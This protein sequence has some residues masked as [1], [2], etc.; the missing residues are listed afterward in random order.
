MDFPIW[1]TQPYL[2]SF[3]QDTSFDIQPIILGFSA[4]IGTQVTLINGELPAGLKWLNPPGATYVLINGVASPSP[5]TI[6]G[7]FTFRISQTNGSIADRTFSIDL[8]P[9]PVAP[10]WSQQQ[11]FLGY[12]DNLSSSTYVLK[13]LPPPGEHVSY[14]LLSTPPGQMTI[15]QSTGLLTYNANVITTDFTA[16]FN[17]R[18]S[19]YTA[20]SDIDL[21]IGVVAAPFSPQWITS[22]GALNNPDTGNNEFV[23]GDFVEIKLE[24]VDVLDGNVSYQLVSAPGGFP[25]VLG[26][27]GLLF[28][29]APDVINITTYVFEVVASSPNGSSSRSFTIQVVPSSQAGLLA[30]ITEPDLGSIVDGRYVEI[31][32]KART[33]R[34]SGTI[35]YSVIGGLLPPHLM[36]EKT[37]GTLIGYCEYHPV[38]RF[39]WFEIQADDGV[40]KIVRQFRIE[41]INRYADQFFGAYIPFAGTLKAANQA[42]VSNLSVRAP[43][44]ETFYRVE[45]IPATPYLNIINGVITGYETP[46][47]IA[48]R[49][50]PWLHTLGLSF[51]RAESTP[52]DSLGSS[53]IYRNINCS[54][55]GTNL[56]VYSSAVYNTNVQT[57]GMIYPTSIENLRRSIAQDLVF[58]NGGS[59]NGLE[60]SPILDWSDGG[61][62]EVIVLNSGQDYKSKPQI[63]VTGSGQGAMVDPILGLVDLVVTDAGQGW[64][65]GDTVDIPGNDPV[66][67]ANVRVMTTGTNGS[68]STIEIIDEGDYRQISSS[69]RLVVKKGTASMEIKPIWGISRVDVIES[70]S[71]YQCGIGFNTKGGEILPDWQDS[72]FPAIE[73]GS[74]PFFVAPLAASLLNTEEGSFWGSPWTPSYMVWTWQGLRWIGKTTFDES[75]T[76]FDGGLTNFQ[77]TEDPRITVFDQ[78]LEVFDGGLTIFDYVD[79]LEYDL[80]QLWGGTL[81]DGGTTPFDL[82]STV[83]D[84]LRPR[85]TSKTLVSRWIT[86]NP[87]IYSGNNAV[88]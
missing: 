67:R 8:T 83:F 20:S 56:R 32:V 74:M 60:I 14:N 51:G 35:T 70:G 42:D 38:S 26:E 40:Q 6:S 50:S 11:S 22:A 45:K 7:R 41:V 75:W 55:S 52:A 49:I 19:S 29:R 13:A 4:G 1:N 82:Y 57:N 36:L 9:I 84:V 48:A 5:Q 10:D 27:T 66:R 47:Q 85:K 58:V 59:G 43:G 71:G 2:G 80:F 63:T 25:F 68:V 78:Q 88:W 12:Q 3:S 46:D 16:I 54:Q 61:L 79:P 62:Q 72:Y 73:I 81:I 34:D 21:S 53:V 87:R 17:V 39:Y 37:K 65:A 23:G 64:T 44:S 30:W 18:A 86:M 24:A 33:R 28:G 31:D 77:E 76:S 69:P 15:D